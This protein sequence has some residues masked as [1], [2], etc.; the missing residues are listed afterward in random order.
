MELQHTSNDI[1]DD[2]STEISQSSIETKSSTLND[3]D[4]NELNPLTINKVMSFSTESNIHIKMRP[5]D[6]V[7][8]DN[9]SF[10]TNSTIFPRDKRSYRHVS[11]ASTPI[12]KDDGKATDADSL[13]PIPISKGFLDESMITTQSITQGKVSSDDMLLDNNNSDNF[14]MSSSYNPTMIHA[15]T[16]VLTNG[17]FIQQNRLA[18]DDEPVE[19]IEIAQLKLLNSFEKI[20]SENR[21]VVFV[22]PTGV[23]K[24]SQTGAF[25]GN[26]RRQ[27]I[28]LLSQTK[29]VS[30][31]EFTQYYRRSNGTYYG[32]NFTIYDTFGFEGNPY[33]DIWRLRKLINFICDIGPKIHAVIFCVTAVRLHHSGDNILRMFSVLGGNEIKSRMKFLVTNAPEALVYQ[34]PENGEK[35]FLV[36]TKQIL[37]RVMG[38]S[39]KDEDIK[40]SDL[41]DPNRFLENDPRYNVTLNTWEQQQKILCAWVKNIKEQPVK[42][43]R[44]SLSQEL[45]SLFYNINMGV[46]IE[47]NAQCKSEY[48]ALLNSTNNPTSTTNGGMFFGLFHWNNHG[49]S[50]DLIMDE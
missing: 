5:L 34:P 10:Q 28:S 22:G 21:T 37:E 33:T 4:N 19:F 27:R 32:I 12:V 50:T 8:D 17:D 25:I 39:I 20:Q 3:D 26:T 29:E 40:T 9:N 11:F 47:K 31:S 24:S 2:L 44:I 48:D 6:D 41:L 16:T 35:P 15:N 43:N 45:Y 46:I 14:K 18:Y 30:K 42:L 49:S 13:L 36:E 38:C 1:N 23:G 7:K